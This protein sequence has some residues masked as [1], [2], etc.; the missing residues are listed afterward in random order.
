MRSTGYKSLGVYQQAHDLAVN[1]HRMT[2]RELPSFEMYEEGSQIRRSSKAVASNL[3]EGYGRRMYR[4][5]YLRF[6]AYAVSSLDETK[7]HLELLRDTDSLTDEAFQPLWAAC[8]R[9]GR[10]LYYFV[11]SVWNQHTD[12]YGNGTSGSVKEPSADYYLPNAELI[13]WPDWFAE[14]APVE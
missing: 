4:N 5:D 8:S 7:E 12:G 11:R 2:L 3:V 14:N 9:L 10:D 1:I 6:L 13:A